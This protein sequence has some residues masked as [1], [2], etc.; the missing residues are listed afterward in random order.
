M[1]QEEFIQILKEDKFFEDY[2]EHALHRYPVVKYYI[3]NYLKLTI[4]GVN[5]SKF[6]KLIS[7]T[8][9]EEYRLMNQAFYSIK[10]KLKL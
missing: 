7:P 9:D 5:L 4:N 2:K 8:T 3:E 10:S 1:T 6:I